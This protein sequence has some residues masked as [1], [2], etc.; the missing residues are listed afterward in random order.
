MLSARTLRWLMWIVHEGLV[1]LYDADALF[2]M[3]AAMLAP[4]ARL[5]AHPSP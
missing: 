4:S 2:R 3:L 1:K 5:L